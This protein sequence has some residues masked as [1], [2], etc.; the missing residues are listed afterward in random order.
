MGVVSIYHNFG[1]QGGAQNVAIRLAKF[2]SKD[3][4]I[5]TR[6]DNC[7][8]DSSFKGCGVVFHKFSIKAILLHRKDLFVSH[9]RNLT[10]IICF[11]NK[12]GLGANIVH[13]AHNIFS[14]YRLFSL[15]PKH[16]VAVSYAVKD[17]LVHYFKIP[18]ERI[19]V[20]Y[21]GLE[22]TYDP[23]KK[24]TGNYK[25]RLLI[26]ARICPVKQ[27]LEI[28]RNLKGHVPDDIEICFAGKGEDLES[29]KVL[30]NSDTHFNYVGLINMRE[31][32]YFY[33]YVCL[34]SEK[35][36]L[37]LS[38]IEG[39]M[40]GKPLITNSI[41]PCLEINKDGDN[42]FVVNDFCEL[43]EK[44][45]SLPRRE[46]EAYSLL[47]L[48]A[49]KKYESCFTEDEMLNNYRNLLQNESI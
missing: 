23:N 36:G 6:T 48:N 21:N 47:S 16:V 22:D 32:L 5:L 37:P 25:T 42:G 26:A 44:I 1:N 11:L 28:I 10:S 20:I 24:I 30:I 12:L 41:E 45:K 17:N 31:E 43:I 27:Q 49:R 9:S 15:Y 3:P 39:C 4:I 38:L 29:L 40:Y 33:D 19:T 8:I 13:V 34:F 46:S 2:F 14:N 7:C 35:E 18:P